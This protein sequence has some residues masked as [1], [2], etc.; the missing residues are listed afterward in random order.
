MSKTD[1]CPID[2]RTALKEVVRA[3]STAHPMLTNVAIVRLVDL[4]DELRRGGLAPGEI[5]KLVA[6]ISEWIALS[7]RPS[8]A[9]GR[10]IPRSTRRSD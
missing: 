10:N 3:H 6:A 1:D 4:C 2:P 5:H 9:S 8:T 7:Y